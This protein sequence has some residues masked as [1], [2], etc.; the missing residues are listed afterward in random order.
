MLDHKHNHTPNNNT[1]KGSDSIVKIFSAP[2]RSLQSSLTPVQHYWKTLEIEEI[3][4]SGRYLD[5]GGTSPV[6]YRLQSLPLLHFRQ[7]ENRFSLQYTPV[8]MCCLAIDPQSKEAHSQTEPCKNNE[9]EETSPLQKP[10]VSDV[11]YSNIHG[12]LTCLP[13]SSPVDLPQPHLVCY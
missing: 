13:T 10:A 12:K 4:L 3:R 1:Q 8:I 6:D 9:P 5:M 7:G 11:C 2:Q